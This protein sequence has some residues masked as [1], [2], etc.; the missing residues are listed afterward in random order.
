MGVS[1]KNSKIYLNIA[2]KYS[3]QD[4]HTMHVHIFG[5]LLLLSLIFLEVLLLHNESVMWSRSMVSRILDF[6]Y[7]ITNW[8]RCGQGDS[9]VIVPQSQTIEYSNINFQTFIFEGFEVFILDDISWRKFQ[10]IRHWPKN[11]VSCILS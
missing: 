9:F 10:K 2:L 3:Q 11:W 4:L 6:S 1:P 7:P 8:P 5:Q